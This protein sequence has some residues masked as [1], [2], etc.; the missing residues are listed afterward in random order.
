MNSCGI[1]PTLPQSFSEAL[2]LAAEQAEE[3]EKARPKVEALERIS[4][5]EGL[6]TVTAAAKSLQINPHSL[7][8]LLKQ[9][10]KAIK[11]PRFTLPTQIF[12]KSFLMY[13]ETVN[14][15]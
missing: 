11:A 9:K 2:R 10:K 8:T 5:S 6:Q 7:F 15:R 1:K 14:G 3:L 12:A 4:L 13:F